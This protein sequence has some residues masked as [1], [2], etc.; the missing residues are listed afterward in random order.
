MP[1]TLIML[2]NS[3]Y[4]L[5]TYSHA[6][7]NIIIIHW[8]HQL[9]IHAGCSLSKNGCYFS[10]VGFQL[11]FFPYFFQKTTDCRCSLSQFYLKLQ[12]FVGETEALLFKIRDSSPLALL[13]CQLC[14]T[15]IIQSERESNST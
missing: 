4:Y 5:L 2:A 10:T 6:K 8:E 7:K 14:K 9:I 11:V 1:R 13:Y 3:N 12:G 15:L